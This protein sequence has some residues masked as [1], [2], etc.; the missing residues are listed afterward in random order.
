MVQTLIY[1]GFT[2]EEAQTFR[3][4]YK[5]MNLAQPFPDL[6]EQLKRGAK[7]LNDIPT[8]DGRVLNTVVGVLNINLNPRYL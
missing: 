6:P 2:P 3:I 7:K 5:G 1:Y 4:Q 8:F